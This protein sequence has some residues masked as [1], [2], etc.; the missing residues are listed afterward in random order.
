MNSLEIQP[1]IEQHDTTDF[2]CY[3]E[4]EEDNDL[5][6]FIK[7]DAL[8]QKNEGWN[9]TY[10]ATEIGSKKIIGF[11]AISQDS[12]SIDS[13]TRKKLGKPY[14]D[15]PAIKIGRF[16][17]DKRYQRKGIGQIIMKYAIGLIV[18]K[19]CPLIGG[20]YITLD[21]Y[22]HR[23]DWYKKHFNFRDNTLIK[24]DGTEYVNLIF[25]IKDFKVD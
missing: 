16:A 24:N 25:P 10:V 13:K 6:N 21:S 20:I 1:I 2:D 7:N 4:H 22:R 8:R 15:I 23:A 18:E 14:C 12:I 9:T 17:V 3:S 5:N 19:V 11:F